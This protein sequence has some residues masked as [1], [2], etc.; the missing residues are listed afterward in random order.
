MSSFTPG[1]GRHSDAAAR[2]REFM[3]LVY[4]DEPETRW[5][6]RHVLRRRWRRFVVAA[7]L[8]DR[9][10][11]QR[12]VGRPDKATF[13]MRDPLEAL[14]NVEPLTDEEAERQRELWRQ[15]RV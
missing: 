7:G 12:A 6:K 13:R 5:F 4:Y 3:A 8:I 1:S 2:D 11:L 15:P 9:L 14:L 10:D